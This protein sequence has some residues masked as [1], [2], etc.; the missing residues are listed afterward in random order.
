MERVRHHTDSSELRLIQRDLAI[1]KGRGG[2]VYVELQPF[3]AV[4]RKEWGIY[5]SASDD[6]GA[7][8]TGAYVEFDLPA[9]LPVQELPQKWFAGGRKGAILLLGTNAS[10][11]DLGA[12]QPQFVC[13]W[14]WYH[15]FLNWKQR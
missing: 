11:L 8:K 3:G 14:K 15:N 10:F 2:G 4:Y 7:G 13:W 5:W 1:R 6:L 9:D 12:L